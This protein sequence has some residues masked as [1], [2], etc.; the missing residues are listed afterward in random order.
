MPAFAPGPAGLPVLG[1]SVA[2][3]RD[4]LGFL[5]HC[6]RTYGDVV[7]LRLG[8]VT[9]LLAHPNDIRHV[10]VGN[11][12]NYV[13][14]TR[15]TGPWGHKRIGRNVLTSEGAEHQRLRRALQP[16]FRRNV[17]ERIASA[18]VPRL[19]EG[20][21]ARWLAAGTIDAGAEMRR[22]ALSCTVSMLLGEQVSR[23]FPDVAEAIDLRRRYVDSL[24]S[25]PWPWAHV[26][27]TRLN[28]AHRK[29]H[30][31]LLRALEAAIDSAST[32][33]EPTVAAVLASNS[34]G[35]ARAELREQLLA[36]VVAG[37]ETVAELLTWTVF[38]L[39]GKPE[40]Q[41]KLGSEFADV[42]GGRHPTAEDLPRLPYT[43][44]VLSEV[45]RLYPPTWLFVR[46]A[47][48]QDELPSGAVIPAGTKVYL[49]QYVTQRDA[50]F[51]ADP[52]R[53][54]ATRFSEAALGT[55]P[56]F[57]YF[58]FGGGPRLCLGETLDRTEATLILASI[59]PR[60]R[61]EPLAPP[62]A[63]RARAG[64][65]LEPSSPVRVVV[66]AR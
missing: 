56:A 36:L 50:R 63:I 38:V 27:P 61:F 37:Y 66:A 49:S 17:I 65:T 6:A 43:E 41:E 29:A 55:R 35:L 21:A 48:A 7:E 19:A 20:A 10:L 11:P 3:L 16:A 40:E 8:G 39:A 2:F 31:G 12:A 42:L 23:R 47:R 57:S 18:V 14:S 54:D 25:S 32:G 5:T 4:K 64:V 13:K 45:L 46:M 26:L 44:M 52:D 53:F 33:E 1:H 59:V 60:L 9:A 58:P 30:G 34:G 22:L 28:R 15:L 51:F 24:L 62:R